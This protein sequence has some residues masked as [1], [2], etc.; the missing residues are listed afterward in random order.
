[1]RFA[2]AWL[3]V[4]CAGPTTGPVAP[5]DPTADDLA[6]PSQAVRDAAAARIRRSYAPPERARWEPL[7]ASIQP[8][9][10]AAS[11]LAKLPSGAEPGP[12]GAGGGG[13]TESYRLDGLWM[14]SCGFIQADDTVIDCELYDD[15]A[16]I[17]VDPPAAFTGV[18]T[19]YFANGQRAYE[20]HYRG[21]VYDGTFTSFHADG[22]TAS[23]RR[24]GPD[25]V[26][27]PG[28]AR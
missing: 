8:G 19:T 22:T 6:S 11:V 16:Q 21:G 5:R 28:E 4:G 2:L 20:I 12:G 13:R 18:W 24:F 26:V 14:L 15:L 23:V 3:A 1:M 10:P 9:D 7:L 25:G 17:W 27:A